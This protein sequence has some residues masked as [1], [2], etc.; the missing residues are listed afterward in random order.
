[1]WESKEQAIDVNYNSDELWFVGIYGQPVPKP[2]EIRKW[3]ENT[4]FLKLLDRTYSRLKADRMLKDLSLIALAYSKLAV[5]QR[6]T[7]KPNRKG[8]NSAPV[9]FQHDPNGNLIE[10]VL[11]L[12]SLSPIAT[13]PPLSLIK[14][15]DDDKMEVSKT[16][17]VETHSEKTTRQQKSIIDEW[18]KDE[19]HRVTEH[20]QHPLELYAQLTDDEFLYVQELQ[21]AAISCSG[22]WAKR[23]RN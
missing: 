12:R 5:Q 13:M 15:D 7:F 2:T 18:V 11:D 6:L 14:E 4:K 3:E 8:E 9:V 23:Q 10:F 21:R 1:M 20:D 22:F 16:F 17:E 19:D